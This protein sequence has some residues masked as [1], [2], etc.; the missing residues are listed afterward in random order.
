MQG[1]SAKVKTILGH[2]DHLFKKRM[3]LSDFGMPVGDIDRQI[4][5]LM[6]TL[7]MIEGKNG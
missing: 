3:R 4:D 1:I 7:R 5:V 2:L 6:N